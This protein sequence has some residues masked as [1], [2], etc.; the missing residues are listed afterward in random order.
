MT[1]T[2]HVDV[3]LLQPPLEPLFEAEPCHDPLASLQTQICISYIA[4]Y[5][6]NSLCCDEVKSYLITSLSD[7]VLCAGIYLRSPDQLYKPAS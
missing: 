4:Y 5:S 2:Y 7:D 1:M 6:L 3:W